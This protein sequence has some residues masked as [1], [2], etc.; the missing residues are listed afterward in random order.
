MLLDNGNIKN[1]YLNSNHQLIFPELS[2]IV[3]CYNEGSHLLALSEALSEELNKLIGYNRWQFVFVP[4]G[5]KD[6]TLDVIQTILTRW[7]STLSIKLT[8]SDYGKALREGLLKAKG[9]WA[10]VINVD[11]W[12]P[13]FLEWAWDHRK[14]YDLIIGSKRSDPY[15]DKRPK[16]RKVLSWGLNAFLQIYFGLVS[17]D[18][19]GQK[20]LNLITL[21]PI[22][23]SCVMSRGQYDT[24]FTLRIQRAGLRIAEVP[25]P[26]TEERKQRNL[27][28]QKIMQ[29]LFDIVKLKRVMKEI[30]QN[31]H[32]I[33]YHRYSRV[34]MEKQI[35]STVNSDKSI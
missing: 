18:T 1:G 15:L 8:K 3:P 20:L 2:V 16:Y 31:R 32:G 27:M 14:N 22:L 9:N 25:V 13:I 12:D 30:V 21:R 6:K 23:E 11:F 34:D 29:N 10:F 24:E 33:H 19:H 35:K 5:C 4:N 17:T 28:I 7:P 26:I